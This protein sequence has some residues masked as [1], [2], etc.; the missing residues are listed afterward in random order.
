M[1]IE[2]EAIAPGLVEEQRRDARAVVLERD[3]Q[4]LRAKGFCKRAAP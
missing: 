1:L 3:T 4:R 2:G